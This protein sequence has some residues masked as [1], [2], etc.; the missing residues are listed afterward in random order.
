M[1][2]GDRAVTPLIDCLESDTRLTRSVQFWRDFAR[3]RQVLP[4][5]EAAFAALT[6]IL[7][8]TCFGPLPDT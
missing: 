7:K 2:E 5:R 3:H 4:V 1:K 8:T 6:E